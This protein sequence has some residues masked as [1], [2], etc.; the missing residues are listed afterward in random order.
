[1][2]MMTGNQENYSFEYN[3]LLFRGQNH[4]SLPAVVEY[5]LRNLA[6]ATNMKDQ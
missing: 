3:V 2:L 6:L 1:M 5:G 4:L